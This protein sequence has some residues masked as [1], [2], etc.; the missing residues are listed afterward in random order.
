MYLFIIRFAQFV[1][2]REV[3]LVKDALHTN[4]EDGEE[5]NVKLQT[6]HQ[7]VQQELWIM[8]DQLKDLYKSNER[9]ALRI[10]REL[11]LILNEHLLNKNLNDDV[12]PHY[13]SSVV[14]IDIDLLYRSA[15]ILRDDL[16]VETGMALVKPMIEYLNRVVNDM[17][18]LEVLLITVN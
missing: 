1:L 14:D 15:E 9:L 4:N 2:Q 5:S 10:H 3:E 12:L 18:D 7:A 16:S 17:G 13:H 11:C 8:L 6:T